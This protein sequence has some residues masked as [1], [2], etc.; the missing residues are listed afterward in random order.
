MGQMDLAYR[1]EDYGKV[2]AACEIIAETMKKHM[3]NFHYQVR[4]C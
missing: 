2:G 1:L 4:V 3:P